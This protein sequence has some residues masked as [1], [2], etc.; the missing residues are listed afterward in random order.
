MVGAAVGAAVSGAM[1]QPA[2]SQP[3]SSMAAQS[4]TFKYDLHVPL[5][6]FRSHGNVVGLVA[7]ALFVDSSCAVAPP[8]KKTSA[9]T[10]A[11]QVEGARMRDRTAG[12][13]AMNPPVGVAS[14]SQIHCAAAPC[15]AEMPPRSEP[16]NP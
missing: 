15:D 12:S 14:P 6:H 4:S 3:I 10:A 5:R 9:T 7:A 16:L 8:A 2:Q 11:A 13:S 1:Q